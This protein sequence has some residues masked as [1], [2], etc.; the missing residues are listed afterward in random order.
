LGSMKEIAESE[1]LT[2]AKG[3][4][5]VLHPDYPDSRSLTFW[6]DPGN[7]RFWT[8]PNTAAEYP[9][10]VE[11]MLRLTGPWQRCFLWCHLG[12]WI[13]STNDPCPNSRL[14]ETIFCVLGLTPKSARVLEFS[15][16]ETNVL[17]AILFTKLVFGWCVADDLF[18]V[19]DH[20]RIILQTD[21]HNVVHASFTAADQMHG[22]IRDMKLEGYDLPIEPPDE[23]FRRP[24]WMSP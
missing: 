14:Q 23:T 19:P 17:A 10:L 2:W 3:E 7:D 12:S 6:P 18:I 15:S 13:E 16:Q 1:F 24:D 8:L 20:G 5:M 21:H 9:D 4:G 22:F 11:T